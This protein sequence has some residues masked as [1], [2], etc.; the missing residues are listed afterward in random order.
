MLDYR[1]QVF[2]EVAEKLN[3][4]RAAESL[5]IS[6]PAVTQHIKVIE[7]HYG[8]PLFR[9]AAGGI[10]LT[11]AGRVLLAATERMAALVHETEAALRDGQVQ[12]TGP[13][14]IGASTT[15]AQYF[16]PGLIARFRQQH[17]SVELTLRIGNT[18]EVAEGVRAARLD[19]G[20][21]EG[22]G[23]RRDLRAVPFYDDEIVCVT[24]PGHPLARR[25]H[26]R[27][28]DLATVPF[29]LREPG[30]GTRDVVER[31]LKQAGLRPA[32]LTL[33]LETESSEAIKGLVAAGD[34]AAFL[35]RLAIGS[36][37]ALKRLV[38]VPVEGLRVR[39][40]FFF[41]F[42]QGPIPAGAAGAFMDF[43]SSTATS[44]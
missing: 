23:E 40:K 2:R 24:A 19:L 35:S 32:A 11:P 14:R 9:R 27:P 30:S 20:L 18:R 44:V 28:A 37:L 8:T 34:A 10:T 29:V 36:E 31:A 25:E 13:L 7:A 3:F 43:I 33:L 6:Q 17:R 42:S 38:V 16:L 1:L 15:I 41:L 39:R 5:H 26:V 22:P 12:L 21:V 4:T